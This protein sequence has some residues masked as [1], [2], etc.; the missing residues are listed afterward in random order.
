MRLVISNENPMRSKRRKPFWSL[1]RRLYQEGKPLT[2]QQVESLFA[3]IHEA[4]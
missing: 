2:R 3:E 4:A 1:A